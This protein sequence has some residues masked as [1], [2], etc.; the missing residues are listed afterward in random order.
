M[1]LYNHLQT[2]YSKGEKSF[3][4]FL[5]DDVFQVSITRCELTW[6]SFDHG[7]NREGP[8][9]SIIDSNRTLKYR[10]LLS[11]CL[12]VNNLNVITRS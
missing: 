7:L 3:S 6:R 10:E 11:N 9:S 5:D 4:L 1:Y 2:S 12:H 8:T